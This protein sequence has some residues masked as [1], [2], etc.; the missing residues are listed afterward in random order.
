M[1]PPL[2]PEIRME[3][4]RHGVRYLL[5]QRETGPLKLI[6]V[7]LIGFGC[8]F[9]GFALFWILLVLGVVMKGTPGPGNVLFALFGLPFLAAGLG[10]VAAGF[11]VLRGHCEIEMRADDLVI[12]ERGAPF[13]WTRWMPL[14]A[15]R[16][17]SLSAGR[18]RINN[19]SVMTDPLSDMGF[20]AADVGAAQPRMV[21]IGYP[22][23][24]LEALAVRL[25]AD[26]AA[27][28]GT[29]LKPTEVLQ[30]DP[31]TGER[32]YHGD[33]FEPPTGTTLRITEQAGGI[34]AVIP[35]MGF[36]G[37]SRFMLTFGGFWLLISTVVGVGFGA[38]ALYGQGQKPP[39]F[40]FVVLGVFLFAGMV[41]LVSSVNLAWRKASLRA[42][43]NEV[44]IVQQS[45]F[46]TNTFRIGTPKIAAICM[47]HSGMTTNNVRINE[48]QLHTADGTKHGYFAQLTTDELLWLATHLRHATG[49]GAEPPKLEE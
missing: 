34:V 7:P 31:L 16:R 22:R 40:V 45:P 1:N 28:T 49:V 12:R 10:I 17:F 27:Q 33:H 24:W 20:L 3:S 35:A 29:V 43:R 8:L 25:N 5:P 6:A 14:K 39:A 30:Q 46:G 48:L 36:K 13:W 42:A 26:I 37:V 23:A 9:G 18:A 41:M 11:F 47:G 32:L 15:I 38:A 4:V 19:Q 2:P 44:I 21:V